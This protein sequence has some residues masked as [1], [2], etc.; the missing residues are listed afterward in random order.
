MDNTQFSQV[1]VDERYNK[2]E[3]VFQN[4]LHGLSK[5]NAFDNETKGARLVHN[6]YAFKSDESKVHLLL[7]WLVK[8]GFMPYDYLIE[9]EQCLND[10]MTQGKGVET[11]FDTFEGYIQK[12]FRMQEFGDR[13]K[14]F[15]L[16][17]FKKRP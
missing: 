9:E 11:M 2:L 3:I 12:C 4:F 17:I 8:K 10:L 14:H 1:S 16:H 13:R 7:M 6:Q 15:S 5:N